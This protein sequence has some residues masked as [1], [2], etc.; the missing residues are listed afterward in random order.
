[1]RKVGFF[2]FLFVFCGGVLADEVVVAQS[3]FSRG[4]FLSDS[5][6][7]ESLRLKYQEDFEEAFEALQQSLKLDS[8]SAVAWY[9][10]SHY[11]VLLQDP[12]RAL[13]SLKQAY[14]YQPDNQSYKSELAEL[15]HATKQYEQAIALYRE[16]AKARPDKPEYGYYALRL[17]GDYLLSQ[18]KIAE[19]KAQ[20]YELTKTV[21]DDIVAWLQLLQIAIREADATSVAALC[22]S[23][24]QQFPNVAEFY[25]YKGM[26]Y[27]LGHNLK[28]ALKVYSAGLAVADEDDR[29]MQSSFLEQMG[30]IYYR[31]GN[32]KKAF[33]AFELALEANPHNISALNNYAYYLS[34][35]KMDL[36]KAERMASEVVRQQP[37][38]GTYIDT[39]AWVLFQ[40][41][42]YNL[43]KF[44]IES[45]ISKSPE[46]S[47]ELFEHYGDILHALGNTAQ[48]IVEWQKAIVR[49][50]AEGEKVKDLERKIKKAK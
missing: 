29:E 1:M 13:A 22:D 24:L 30:D 31:Q 7:V 46:P 41:G 39:Y 10:L 14:A 6:F 27:L 43:A 40:K 50:Q 32:K 11:Y 17:S 9:E 16:L 35:L 15:Y 37:N 20:Y 21:P 33:E 25:F 34:L 4:K 23:A 5:L 48:A 36:D 44:Y 42:N 47:S 45:A 2:V 3:L 38:N 49:K 8:T 19:A 18:G 12:E 28:A 26:S